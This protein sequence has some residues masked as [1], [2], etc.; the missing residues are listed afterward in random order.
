MRRQ[1]HI[2]DLINEYRRRISFGGVERWARW[3]RLHGSIISYDWWSQLIE[4][5]TALL[6]APHFSNTFW[7]KRN[8]W[9][10]DWFDALC[11]SSQIFHAAACSYRRHAIALYYRAAS[12]R[13]I[14]CAHLWWWK[15]VELDIAFLCYASKRQASKFWQ[16]RQ[17]LAH[18]S[19]WLTL[20]FSILLPS[21]IA[22]ASMSTW[23]MPI[24]EHAWFCCRFFFSRIR[25][26]KK[27]EI[28][29]MS[30]RFCRRPACKFKYEFSFIDKMN[31]HF[32]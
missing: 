21:N 26:A 31:Y 6:R 17:C 18:C 24:R 12:W 23:S 13:R 30:S 4:H 8:G 19:R 28:W 3:H 14:V 32:A 16:A 1:C 15:S 20:I 27:S 2:N 9:L 25:L 7:W 22:R 10:H 29:A 11:S 5:G